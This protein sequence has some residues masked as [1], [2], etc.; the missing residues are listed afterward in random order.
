MALPALI[1]KFLNLRA[2]CRYDI[3]NIALSSAEIA[4]Q[5]LR[6][7]NR[8]ARVEMLLALSDQ[9][10]VVDSITRIGL[11]VAS[12]TDN[13]LRN[14]NRIARLELYG[15][16][17]VPPPEGVTLENGAV[18]APVTIIGDGASGP[19]EGAACSVITRPYEKPSAE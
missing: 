12:M 15:G 8:L 3:N 19:V 14:S 18:V 5:T 4:R 2:E 10:Q 9:S 17:A 1:K 16:G 7:A 6:T 11:D 13:I